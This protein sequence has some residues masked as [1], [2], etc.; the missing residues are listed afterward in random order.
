MVEKHGYWL[1]DV[2][3]KYN[4]F[5][6][7]K[8]RLAYTNTLTYPDLS[9]HIPVLEIYTNSVVWNNYALKPGRAQNFDAQVSVFENSIGLFSVGGYLKRI[10]D[11]IFSQETHITN[12]LLYPGL[13]NDPKLKGKT[14]YTAYNNPNRVD[15]WGVEAEWQ[16]HFWYLPKPFN[17]LVMNVNYTH[18]FSEAKY[19]YVVTHSV[20]TFPPKPIQ[21]VDSSYTDRLFSQPNDIVNFSLGY[22]YGKF[23]ILASLIYQSQVFNETNFYNSMRSDK[24]EYLRWDL[25]VKQGLPWDGL[26]VYFDIHN[27][28]SEDDIFVVRGSGYPRSQSSYGMTADLGLRWRL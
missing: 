9:A 24:V 27:L 25:S 3:L 1:P 18:I 20:I 26:E 28:N 23:S 15:L 5:S 14:L 10:D 21:Y 11:L 16:T 2:I 7:L 13:P 17:G 8:A 19:P 22:D 12:P 4:P 6:W